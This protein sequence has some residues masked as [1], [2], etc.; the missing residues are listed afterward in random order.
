VRGDL[1]E[2]VILHSLPASLVT[3]LSLTISCLPAVSSTSVSVLGLIHL[4][5]ALRVGAV[6]ERGK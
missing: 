4:V 5:V 2:P 3:S 6:E 1:N